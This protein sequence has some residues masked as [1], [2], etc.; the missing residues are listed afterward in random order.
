M[1]V[2]G[3]NM[4]RYMLTKSLGRTILKLK[5][6]TNLKTNFSWFGEYEE[7]KEG[8]PESLGNVAVADAP[9]YLSVNS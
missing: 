4:V 9:F 7:D 2:Y 1:N 8:A 5:I 3:E 6:Y